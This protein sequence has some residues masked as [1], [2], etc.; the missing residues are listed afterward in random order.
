MLS[1]MGN[2]YTFSVMTLLITAIARELD[3]FAHVFGDDLIVSSDVVDTCVSVLSTIGFKTNSKKTFTEGNFRE[4]CGGFTCEDKYIT[5]YDFHCNDTDMDAVVTVNKVGIIAN[6]YPTKFTPLWQ[7]LHNDLIGV[8]P[9]HLLRAYFFKKDHAEHTIELDK[10]RV[11]AA[12]RRPNSLTWSNRLYEDLSDTF[13]DPA[14]PALSEGVFLSPNRVRRLQSKD[15]KVQKAISRLG[16]SHNNDPLSYTLVKSQQ[17][18]VYT[19]PGIGKN[20][21]PCRLPWIPI[22]NAPPLLG[23][24]WLDEGKSGPVK[25]RDT[26]EVSTWQK[27]PTLR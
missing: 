16:R 4:S 26:Y 7:Q 8:V 27:L 21:K 12:R 22:D 18:R 5:S 25:L 1:P 13:S 19:R 10:L 14:L 3:S 17:N 11:Q 20:G 2:G 9:V 6:S 15:E 24:C 23:W